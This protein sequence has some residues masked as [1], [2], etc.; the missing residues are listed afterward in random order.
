MNSIAG[1]STGIALLM[2]AALL[3]ALFAMGVFSATGVGAHEGDDH[4][5]VGEEVVG[6][7]VHDTLAGTAGLTA[8]TIDNDA[9]TP[10]AT[11]NLVEEYDA[12]EHEYEVA[13]DRAADELTIVAN[14][15][16]NW[17]AAASVSFMIDGK[18]V[19][20]ADVMRDGF[21]DAATETTN[22]V[23]T[24][25]IDLKDGIVKT[26]TLYASDGT[27]A[28]S[29]GANGPG[30][31]TITLTYAAANTSDTGSG[32]TV[33]DLDLAGDDS[34]VVLMDGPDDQ[35]TPGPLQVQLN[36]NIV[37]KLPDFTVPD[38]IDAEDISVST[39]TNSYNP[40][41]VSVSGTT[42]TLRMGNTGTLATTAPADVATITTIFIAKRAEIKN[43][44]RA[45]DAP[46]SYPITAEDHNG[47]KAVG[48]AVV[49]RKV[50]AKPN[51]GT[52]GTMTTIGGS[53]LPEGST[54][55]EIIRD[56][57]P[58]HKIS[59]TVDDDGTFKHEI[60]TDAKDNDE[61]D[62]FSAGKNTINVSDARGKPANVTGSFTINPSFTIDPES[63]IPG[64]LVTIT[65][66]DI[67][68]AVNDASFAGRGIDD[69]FDLDDTV[70]GVDA[71][72]KTVDAPDGEYQIKMPSGVRRGSVE[73]RVTVDTDPGTETLKK[74]ITIATNSLDVD[75]DTAV[76]GQQVTITGDGFTKN[77]RI[78]AE[79]IK[80][81]T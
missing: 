2:A 43:P 16:G 48:H 75:P 76:P 26:I 81:D 54:T 3:A 61:K 34:N 23:S 52:R 30:R 62:V 63:P 38:E 56:G 15:G 80:V 20:A 45:N 72:V 79:D 17:L 6:V 67:E 11:A 53:G 25:V 8:T 32:G 33:I 42:L 66:S 57:A 10:T 51:K 4:T 36:Q 58:D 46:D 18:A 35:D 9:D 12:D 73:M 1:K 77:G 13:V 40:S 5:T 65:L 59:V 29:N 68:G 27:A 44:P 31:Y 64:Q 7:L 71:K 69:A 74:T 47:E 37:I 70:D 78:E 24:V 41:D 22:A 49:L 60:T 39:A 50:S 19:D 28:D 21:D 14:G 55:V